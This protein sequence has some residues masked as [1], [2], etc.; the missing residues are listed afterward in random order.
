[1]MPVVK[2]EMTEYLGRLK[3]GEIK[4]YKG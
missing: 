4:K 1:L 2:E 3:R